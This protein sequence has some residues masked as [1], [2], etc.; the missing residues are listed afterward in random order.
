MGKV[1]PAVGILLAACGSDTS[2]AIQV[3]TSDSS[4]TSVE[5]F[6]ADTQCVACL[7]IAPP[8]VTA[9]Q[10]RPL[11]RVD[12]TITNDRFTTSVSNGIAGFR[13][14]SSATGSTSSTIT[15]LAAVGYTRNGAAVAFVLDDASFSLDAEKGTIRRYEL[16]TRTIDSVQP[17]SAMPAFAPKGPKD[18]GGGGDTPTNH[19]VVWRSPTAV[20]T[21]P[22]C[23]AIEHADGTNEFLVPS[24]DPDCDGFIANECDPDWYDYVSAPSI[25]PP[26]TCLTDAPPQPAC[27]LGANEG[28]CIDGST[29]S[30]TSKGLY[31]FPEKAC[32]ACSQFDAGPCLAGLIEPSGLATAGNVAA[33]RCTAKYNLSNGNAICSGATTTFGLGTGVTQGCSAQFATFTTT[34]TSTDLGLMASDQIAFTTST[35]SGALQIPDMATTS[36]CSVTIGNNLTNMTGFKPSAALGHGAFTLVVGMHTLVMPVVVDFVAGNCGSDNFS[37]ALD[38]LAGAT[39]DSIYNCAH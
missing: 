28:R 18:G 6:V 29:T 10:R 1:A 24:A 13:L 19:V 20:A 14:E 15:K 30:C 23:L 8:G 37:C 7:G 39:P 34:S 2:V 38:G 32:T 27:V 4:I 12:Y 17:P 25:Q 16:T 26:T 22:S 9:S 36:P 35:F 5:L 11:G 33:L 21:T 3:S 31:C